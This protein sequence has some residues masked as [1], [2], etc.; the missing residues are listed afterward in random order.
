M[1]IRFTLTLFILCT[2]IFTSHVQ[3]AVTYSFN[4]CGGDTLKYERIKNLEIDSDG[5]LIAAVDAP[6]GTAKVVKFVP[7]TGSLNLDI[8][9]GS[10]G[11][12]SFDYTTYLDDP[13]VYGILNGEDAQGLAISPSDKIFLARDLYD[14]GYYYG[15]STLT[16]DYAMDVIRFQTDGDIDDAANNGGNPLLAFSSDGAEY[17]EFSHDVFVQDIVVDDNGSVYSIGHVKKTTPSGINGNDIA[18]ASW[19][20]M[21]QLNTRFDTDGMVE[22]NLGSSDNATKGLIDANGMLVIV[23]QTDVNGDDDMFIMRMSLD[24]TIDTSFGDD[25]PYVSGSKKGYTL[26]D[27]SGDDSAIGVLEVNGEYIIGG[28]NESD[29]AFAKVSRT[30]QLVTSFAS[31]GKKTFSLDGDFTASD[32]AMDS[33]NIVYIVGSLEKSGA[34]SDLVV[35]NLNSRTGNHVLSFGSFGEYVYD[36]NGLEQEGYAIAIDADDNIYVG[37]YTGND[38]I[39][40]DPHGIPYSDIDQLIIGL[41]ATGSEIF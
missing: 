14:L 10:A 9:F 11:L 12:A 18:I 35:V 1:N 39:T 29:V 25:N 17:T 4:E 30:G 3:A 8:N 26:I 41:D 5:N 16:N 40:C 19:N 33:N 38:L 24:G 20:R 28:S 7:G 27:F 31:S 34:D 37:G 22:L 2:V 21:G 32:M 36:Y 13:S 6:I 15:M 23:G